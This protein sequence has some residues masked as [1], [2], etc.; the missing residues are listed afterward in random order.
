VQIC[1]DV[2]FFV[3]IRTGVKLAVARVARGT[4]RLCIQKLANGLASTAADVPF[5]AA[6]NREDETSRILGV[7]QKLRLQK[8]ARCTTR[9][10]LSLVSRDTLTC[11]LSMLLDELSLDLKKVFLFFKR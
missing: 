1:A 9:K 6:Q 3:L 8:L 2:H 5:S 4:P 10:M 11:M 7:I